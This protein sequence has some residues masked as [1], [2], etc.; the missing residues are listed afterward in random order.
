MISSFRLLVLCLCL[1]ANNAYASKQD[2]LDNLRQRIIN[3]QQELEK[4]SESKS[5]A[6]DALRESERA[7]SNSNRKLAELEAQQREA[8]ETLGQLQQHGRQLEK[9]MQA[10]QTLLGK[11]LYQQ[12]LGGKQEY[13]K[14][15]LNNRDPNQMAREIQYYEYIARSRADWL[16]TLRANL[17][18][19]HTVADQTRQKSEEIAALQAEQVSQKETLEK[20]KRTHQQVLKKIALNLA[21]PA[22]ANY[23]CRLG[24]FV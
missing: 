5:E 23:H 7:I 13:L 6:A 14:M 16:Q 3:L 21:T 19:L 11:L 15:L 10:Q 18:Q 1:L 20:D 2:E 4:T 24:L 12:Y 22:G 8:G 17:D 9:D